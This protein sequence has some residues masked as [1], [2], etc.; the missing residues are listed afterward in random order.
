MYCCFLIKCVKFA[1]ETNGWSL[2][3]TV[4]EHLFPQVCLILK[5]H[6]HEKVYLYS[7]S[8]GI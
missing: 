8:V 3:K 1:T 6:N 2:G 4:C 5:S 7:M